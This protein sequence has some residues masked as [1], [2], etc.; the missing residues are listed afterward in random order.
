[1]VRKSDL[2][3]YND[4]VLRRVERMGLSG[5]IYSTVFEVD[6]ADQITSYSSLDEA[7]AHVLAAADQ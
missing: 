4:F 6:G 7:R 2:E 1:M 3:R 5:Q